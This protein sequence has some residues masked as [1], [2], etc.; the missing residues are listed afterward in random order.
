MA[1]AETALLEV[2]ARLKNLNSDVSRIVEQLQQVV[3][4]KT[5]IKAG[6]PVEYL[7]PNTVISA[8]NSVQK[9]V[10]KPRSF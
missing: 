2:E 7:V 9:S 3:Y 8:M 6:N 4:M 10:S 5:Q 1:Y